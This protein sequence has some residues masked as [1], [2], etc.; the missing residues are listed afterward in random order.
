[1]VVQGNASELTLLELPPEIIAQ[2]LSK[3][4]N[5]DLLQVKI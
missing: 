4:S 5:A 1:M 2:I 3:I